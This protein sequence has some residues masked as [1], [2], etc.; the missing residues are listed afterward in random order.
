MP[1][2]GTFRPTPVFLRPKDGS[3]RPKKVP[4][5]SIKSL[6]ASKVY[7]MPYKADVWPFKPKE[8]PLLGLELTS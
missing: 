6:P 8:C 1:T 2:Q 4:L 7:I 5:R 3:F